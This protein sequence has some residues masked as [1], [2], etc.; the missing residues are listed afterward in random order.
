[1]DKAAEK[2]GGDQFLVIPFKNDENIRSSIGKRFLD[3]VKKELEI[4][5]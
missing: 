5:E 3:E 4:R 2:L 1:M